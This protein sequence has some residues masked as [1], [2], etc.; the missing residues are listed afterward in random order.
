MTIKQALSLRNIM[1]ILCILMLVLLGQKGIRLHSKIGT[2]REAG[3]LYAAGDLVAAENQYRLAQANDSIHYR[4]AETAARLQELAPVTAIRSGLELLKLKIED[5]LTTKDF[6]GFMES[7]ASLLS[8]KSQYMKSG[9]PYESYYRQLSADSGVSDQLGT[10]FQQ[11]KVQFLA[12]LAAGRSRSSSAINEADIFKWNLLRIPDVYL[13]GADAKKELLAL[14]FKTYDITRLKALA[15]AGSFSPMLDYALSLADAYSSH[16]YT[17]PWIASQIEES[18]KLILSKDMDS[19][20]IAAFSAHAAAYRKY[21][22]SAGLASSKV[23]SRIDSTAAKLLRGAARLVRNGG[24]AEAIQRYSDLSPLQDTTAEIAAAQLAWNMAEPARLLPGGETPGKYVLTTSVSGKY[25]VRLAVAGTDSSGQL[26]YADMSEDGAVTTRTGEVIP[27]FET[28]S[29]LAFD[30]QLSALAGVPVVVAEGSRE[31][32]RTSFAGYTIKPEGISLLFSFAGSSYKLQPDDA[33]IRVANADM[34]EGSEGQ[35]AIYRQTNGVY[36]FAEIY[37]EYPLI[38]ASE[39]ELHPLETVTL[40]VDIYI[41]TTGRP[42][43][44]AGGRYLAL[45][46]N[47]GTV[48]GPALATGQFQYGYDYAG[49]DAGEEYVPVFIVESLGSTNP[50]PN[51]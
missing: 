28:L 11:F 8:L 40:Q 13:G 24:Y 30:D 18:A 31:D 48:T 3:R 47:V 32:G 44:I 17:A 37:Q 20:Q 7:Y 33:S 22:A 10:G 15:A 2:V 21:A 34:G 49:T 39:L 42:V 19:G 25:G 16:S 6:D 45:Q 5:Q 9:G 51:P 29:R 50:I 36:Q 38:D 26:Y 46:G 27:G 14:E 4:E 1:I 35:T 43:A 41:D 12:E 23:L